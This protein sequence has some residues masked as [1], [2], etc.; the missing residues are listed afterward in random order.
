MTGLLVVCG[1]EL[2]DSLRD[3]RTLFSALVLGPLLGPVI[4]VLLVGALSGQ[5]LEEADEALELPIIGAGTAPNLVAWLRGQGVVILPPPADPDRAI[6]EQEH[7]VI[8]RIPDRFPD[9]LRGGRPAVL[10]L[11]LDSSR[12]DTERVR[13]RVEALVGSYGAELGARRLAVRGID[14]ALTRAVMLRGIDYS[15]PESRGGLVLAMLPYFVVI[16]LF[17]GGMA[18]AIDT[19]AGEIE[20][21]SLEPLLLNPLPRWQFMA[22]KLL[23]T[24][25][26]TLLSLALALVAFTLGV[27]FIPADAL[28]MRLNL[29]LAMALRL[30]LL[31]A[32]VALIAAALLTVLAAF[33]RSFREAQSYMGLVVL[34]PMAPALYLLVNPVT[35]ELWMMTVPLLSQH[36]LINEL[37]SGRPILPLWPVLSVGSSLLLGSVLALVAAMIYSQP[38]LVFRDG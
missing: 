22:G 21:R 6:R 27:P 17:L 13:Q 34:I 7:D 30:W 26:L 37:V 20:R 14:P 1:K 33:A 35:P 9:E 3:R 18:I 25:S 16:G 2:R 11:L 10:E 5:R 15:T 38:R 23:A 12:S 8:L 24:V 31:T 32:P 29:D 28:D 19:T 4:W 36:V